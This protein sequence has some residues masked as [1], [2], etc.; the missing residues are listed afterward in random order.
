MDAKKML[1]VLGTI[2][3]LGLALTLLGQ[4][5]QAASLYYSAGAGTTWD[6]TNG[7]TYWSNVSNG[8]YSLAWSD[9][10]DAWFEGT[11]GTVNLLGPIGAVNSITFSSDGYTLSGGTINLTGA[12]GSITTG[13]GADT[14]GSVLGGSVGLTKYGSGMLVLSSAA[15]FSGNVTISNGTLQAGADKVLPTT[16]TLTLGDGVANTSGVLDLNTGEQDLA[17]LLTAGTGSANQVIDSSGGGLLKLTIAGA[18]TF[19]G[20]LGGGAGGNNFNLTL[21]GG[22][23]LV[24][25]GTNN[26]YSGST[27]ISA[28]TLSFGSAGSLGGGTSQ[29]QLGNNSGGFGAFSYAGSNLTITR[30]FNVNLGGGQIDNSGSGLLTISGGSIGGNAPLTLSGAANTIVVS[31]IQTGT[32]SLT[33]LGAG[34]ATLTGTDIYTGNTTISAGTL[35]IGGAGVLGSGANYAGTISNNGA[36]V[37]NTSINQTLSG[38]IS[39]P[40]NLYQNGSN[41]T[42]LSG[43]NTYSGT[44]TVNAGTLI[45]SGNNG[46]DSRPATTFLVNGGT[47]QATENNNQWPLSHNVSL[48]INGG[49]VF[50]YNGAGGDTYTDYIGTVTLNSSNGSAAVENDTS[51]GALRFGRYSPNLISSGSVTNL[52]NGGMVLVNLGNLNQNIETD[53]NLVI[54]GVIRDLS[55]NAGASITKTGTA[56]LILLGANSYSGSTTIT[57]GTLQVGNGGSLGLI[58]SGAI[59]NNGTL[60]FSRSDVSSNANLI[61]ATSPVSGTGALIANAGPGTIGILGTVNQGSVALSSNYA[62]SG[63]NLYGTG[64]ASAINLLANVTTTGNQSYSGVVSIG[65]NG[66][67]NWTESLTTTGSGGIY[68]PSGVISGLPGYWSS[69]ILNLTTSAGNGPVSLGGAT[70]S[71]GVGNLNVNSGT[72]NTTLSGGNYYYDYSVFSSNVALAGNTTFQNGSQWVRGLQFNGS[73]TS[74]GTYGLTASFGNGSAS[75]TGTGTGG[76]VFNIAST[77]TASVPISGTAGPTLTGGGLLSLTGSSNYTGATTLSAG[78]LVAANNAALGN[79]S[80]V[81]LSPTGAAAL[82]FTTGSPAIGSLASS[83][84]GTSSVVLGAGGI[85]TTLTLGGNGTST[86]YAG[87][88]ADMSAGTA[89]AIGS[90]VKLGGGVQTLAGT[91]SY[92]GTT[93]VNAGALSF[94]QRNALYNANTA[95]WTGGNIVVQSGAILG[96][97]VAVR[98]PLHDNR[99]P[100]PAGPKQRDRRLPERVFAWYG[101]HRRQ[102]HLRRRDCQPQRRRQRAWLGQARGKHPDPDGQQHLHRQYHGA[103]RHAANGRGWNR[104]HGR[105]RYNRDGLG[106]HV[107]GQPLR[108]Y[109]PRQFL[110]RRGHVLQAGLEYTHVQRNVNRLH[111]NDQSCRRHVHRGA[112]CQ[113]HESGS[114]FAGRQQHRCLERQWDLGSYYGQYCHQRIGKLGW[115]YRHGQHQFRRYDDRDQHVFV[116]LWLR[117]LWQYQFLYQCLWRPQCQQFAWEHSQRILSR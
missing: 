66:S 57:A 23:L 98:E 75:T 6:D 50:N 72:A 56:N 110:E 39:G 20:R 48:N 17:G 97:G 108:Q 42:T 90:L 60:V 70:L 5:A 3:V 53:T 18:N 40:G 103:R 99:Y 61:S 86:S 22:G 25:S 94:G 37:V 84:T 109:V 83:G 10:C 79:N 73:L 107:R 28:G 114:G 11:A 52:W 112:K 49:G 19:G 45:V 8:P 38:A 117:R 31:T 59:I 54:G 15:G 2:V 16:A 80:A 47:L 81:T 30:G 71:Y 1:R 35:A 113:Y 27:S 14:I 92:T 7:S 74:S 55:G 77:A 12:G 34:L 65:H 51:T 13:P 58:G 64:Y 115:C 111:R 26:T 100:E 82:N 101:H 102:L 76:L 68:L 91:D 9:S 36:L 67:S 106:R 89:A 95:S 4:P 46:F 62:S 104:R 24:L 105:P 78:T 29:I 33:K 85:A 44:A 93:S 88:I 21:L 96:L 63:Q 116:L 43:V 32:G 69:G 41:V 87:T